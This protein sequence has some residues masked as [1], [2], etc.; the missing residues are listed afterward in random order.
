MEDDTDTDT[1]TD[2]DTDTDFDT[3]MNTDTHTDTDTE[4]DTDNDTNTDGGR[5][6]MDEVSLQK[7]FPYSDRM[8]HVPL[9]V[10][11]SF[12]LTKLLILWIFFVGIIFD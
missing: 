8:C 2:T 12:K 11:V 6:I 10:I 3:V 4:I 1:H 7:S 5:V 9:R